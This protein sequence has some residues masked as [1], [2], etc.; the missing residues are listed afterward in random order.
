VG[1]YRSN[2]VAHDELTARLMRENESLKREILS[3]D[4]EWVGLKTLSA[5]RKDAERWRYWRNFWPALCR[6]EV[7]R[8]ARLDLRA[9]HVQSPA[10][11]DKVTDAAIDGAP[12][13]G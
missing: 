12:A 4:G 7:A 8:F 6:M 3:G 2:E 13:V 10:D 11:M 5:L 1:R 9:V